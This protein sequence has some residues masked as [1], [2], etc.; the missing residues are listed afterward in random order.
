MILDKTYTADS[1]GEYYICHKKDNISFRHNET[2][3]AVEYISGISK[4]THSYWVNN[5][6]QSLNDKPALVRIRNGDLKEEYWYL[7]NSLHRH[8]GYAYNIIS[9]KVW[10]VKD[11]KHRLNAP[12]V[13]SIYGQEYWEFGNLVK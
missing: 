13:L 12:A 1:W 10:F 9:K 11:K 5:M 6:R 3:K 2:D 8:K 7:N 4:G